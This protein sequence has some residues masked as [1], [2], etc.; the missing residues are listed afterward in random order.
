MRSLP[1]FV[2][3]CLGPVEPPDSHPAASRTPTDVLCPEKGRLPVAGRELEER[4]SH[5]LRGA[6]VFLAAISCQLP[7]NGLQMVRERLLGTA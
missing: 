4:W 1:N 5:Q 6:G 3:I 2:S 7:L